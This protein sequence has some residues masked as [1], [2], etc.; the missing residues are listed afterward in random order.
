MDRARIAI[1]GCGPGHPDW[2]TPAVRLRMREAEVLVGAARLLELAE[3]PD[4]KQIALGKDLTGAL[5]AVEAARGAGKR[6]AILVSGDP[7][8][9]SLAGRVLERFGAEACE[10]VPGISA[11]QVACARLGCPWSGARI[12]SAHGRVPEVSPDALVGESLI[13]VLGG[14][15]GEGAVAWVGRTVGQMARTHAPW[16]GRDLTLAGETTFW[17]D[18]DVS[19][20][21]LD[22]ELSRP[23]TILA[24]VRREGTRASPGTQSC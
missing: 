19:M 16:I 22:A 12:L 2:V 24:L 20:D 21:T 4:A 7:G 17:L 11:V 23:R 9:Y 14:G 13:L 6:V 18:P 10:V 1:L 3:N 5:D 15:G 8:M